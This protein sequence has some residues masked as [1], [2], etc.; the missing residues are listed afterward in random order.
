LR[1]YFDSSVLI[2][3]YVAEP[4]SELVRL[5]LLEQD[6]DIL[7]NDLQE[8][9]VRNGIR[10]KVVR[11]QITEATAAQSLAL[12]E[13]DC[14]IGIIKKKA[15]AWDLVYKKAEQLSHRFSCHQVCRSFDLLHV[16]VAVVSGVKHFASFDGGQC[17]I[18]IAA[19]LKL[20]EFRNR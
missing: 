4:A 9:E 1:V 6:N 10:Q 11:G 12:L 20:V 5:F 15:V 7:L 16:A 8:I 2:A 13:N 18:A 19:G 17:K 3:L 14:V